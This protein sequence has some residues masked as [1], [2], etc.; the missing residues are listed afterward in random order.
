MP[1]TISV[2]LDQFYR[3]QPGGIATYVRGLIRGLVSLH[4]ESS[5][6]LIGITP[7]GTPRL[8]VDDLATVTPKQALPVHRGCP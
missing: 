5:L 7:V 8:P 3:P 1:R 6:Q 2:A 4:E